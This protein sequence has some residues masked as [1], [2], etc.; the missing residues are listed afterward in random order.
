[1][2]G[3]RRGKLQGERR[4][5]GGGFHFQLE[6][7]KTRRQE[8]EERWDVNSG[9]GANGMTPEEMR[10]QQKREEALHASS[11]RVP[12]RPPWNVHMSIEELDDNE[13]QAFLIWRRSLAR[14]E[15]NAKLMVTPFEKN[16][17]IWRQLWRV[18][19]RSHLLVMVV[20]SRD[21]LFYRCPEAY[22]REV[23]EHKRTLLLVNK[24]DLLPASVRIKDDRDELLARLQSEA[25]DILQMRN[26][27]SSDTEPSN[28]QSPGENVAGSSTSNNVVVGFICYREG[29]PD[30]N[31]AARRIL[32]DYIDGKLHH[33]EIP[34]RMSIVELDSVN[35]QDFA[36]SGT[37]DV[38]VT[39]NMSG[40]SHNQQK[41]PQRRKY[42]SSR[43]GN[44]DEDGMPVVRFL[45]KPINTSHV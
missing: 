45:Q 20:D 13:R 34:P 2:G 25:E 36:S 21:P 3:G 32:K 17:D 33:Y 18:V 9:F 16:L 42:R 5:W 22:A 4:W 26:S 23:D 40:T 37:K 14:L 41:K 35:L 31:R 7:G 39:I 43:T 15:E 44:E 6:W 29:L 38:D 8:W 30:E 11:L 12:R 24:A 27:S 10:K 1:M 19:E 28:I